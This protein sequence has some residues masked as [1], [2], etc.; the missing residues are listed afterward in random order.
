MQPRLLQ[1]KLIARPAPGIFQRQTQLR[2]DGRDIP[3]AEMKRQIVFSG[4]TFRPI[5]VAPGR[6]S[7]NLMIEVRDGQSKTA[8]F[9]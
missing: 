4:Q 9:F 7:A 5:R 3:H 1:E 2:G 6:T 8:G